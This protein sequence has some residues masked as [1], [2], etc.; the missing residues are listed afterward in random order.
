[1]RAVLN[2]IY[3]AERVMRFFAGLEKQAQLPDSMRK[4]QRSMVNWAL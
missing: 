1:M 2:P 3:G 4:S